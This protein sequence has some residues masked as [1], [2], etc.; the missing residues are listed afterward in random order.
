MDLNGELNE[1]IKG[2]CAVVS[3]AAAIIIRPDNAAVIM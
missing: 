2:S 3:V 1:L